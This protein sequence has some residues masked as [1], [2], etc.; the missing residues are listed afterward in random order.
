MFPPNRPLKADFT[1]VL[2]QTLWA[3]PLKKVVELY[4]SGLSGCIIF[5][6]GFNEKLGTSE[7][8]CMADGWMQ[9]GYPETDLII[10]Q[11]AKNTMENMINAKAIFES[12]AF[13]NTTP[14]INIVTIN[15]HM[16]RA[17]ETFKYVFADRTYDIGIVS[18]PS[19]YC[20]PRTWHLN[21]KGRML[22]MTELQKIHQ[23]LPNTTQTYNGAPQ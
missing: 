23:Y 12:K 13:F 22:V 19:I 20:D 11:F 14:K 7:A 17:L 5:T 18:Y 1:I 8:I 9:L 4:K 6:G 10:D 15:F 2:G 21:K 3:R 16:R